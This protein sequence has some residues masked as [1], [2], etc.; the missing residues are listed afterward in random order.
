[1]DDK[2]RVGVAVI[3]EQA[4]QWL[5]GKRKNAHGSDT[6]AFPGGHL[7]WQETPEACA[8]REVEEEVGVRISN[9]SRLSFTNDIF[10]NDNKHYIT[11]FMKATE[12]EGD[13]RVMEPDKCEQ[14]QWFDPKQ[15]PS[16]LF[17]PIE[18]LLK[19]TELG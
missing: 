4:G 18:N 3:L 5:L 13:I 1:M 2:V 19:K 8:I 11:L 16:P 6:W 14:W 7:E 9:P 10:S 15:L 17:L 12:F